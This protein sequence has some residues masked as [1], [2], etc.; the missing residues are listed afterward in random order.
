MSARGPSWPCSSRRWGSRSPGS[1]F[2][3]SH[4]SASTGAFYRCV[5]ALPPLF[6]LARLEDRRYGKRD[7]RA[8]SLCVGRRRFLRSGSDPLAQLDRARRRRAR[9]RASAI[10]RSCSSVCSPGLCSARSRSARRWLR[11]RSSA[12]V[13]SSSPARS[14]RARTDQNPR[15][16]AI[17]GV[18]TGVAYAGFLL[19]P[20][21]GEQRPAPP[22]RTSVHGD[23]L[24]CD[25]LRGDRTRHRRPRPDAF[26]LRH[27]LACVLLA[28][29][30]QVIG[31]LLISTLAAAAAR[32][33]H[34][35]PADAPAGAVGDLRGAD[36]RRVA[37]APSAGRRRLHPRRA[38][39][40]RRSAGAGARARSPSSRVTWQLRLMPEAQAAPRLH[41]HAV[42]GRSAA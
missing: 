21:A 12:S 35:D 16:G 41:A 28:L 42:G 18:L 38:G 37:V 36:H 34:L 15:L 1:L 19:D 10:R 5:W 20:A 33:R 27:G 30:S 29:S 22:G 31:W 11:F 9:D 32:G 6:V 4:V 13:S 26:A 2:R 23:A 40:T 3:L 17:Y 14:S 39:R 7:R 24:V 8:V 25:R